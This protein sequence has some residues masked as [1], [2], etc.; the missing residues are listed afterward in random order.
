MLGGVAQTSN[1][2][3]NVSP[4]Q[5]RR[6]Q[7]VVA[8]VLTALAFFALRDVTRLREGLPWRN[9]DEFADFYCAGSALNQRASPYTYEPLRHCEHAVNQGESFRARLFRSNPAIAVPAPQPP[10]D[11]GP[12]AVLARL[13]AAQARTIDALAIVVAVTLCVVGLAAIGVPWDLAAAALLLSTG[14]VELN[15]AQVVPFALLALVLCGWCLARSR[16][17]QAGLT[18]ALTAIEPTLGLPVVLALLLFVP[19]ARLAALVTLL[20]LVLLSLALVGAPG[21]VQYVTAVLPA[22]AASEVHFPFQYSLTFALAFLGATDAVARVAGTLS[23]LLLLAIALRVAPRANVALGRREVLVYVPALCAI[24]AGPFLHQEELCFALPGLL[25]LAVSTQGRARTLAAIALCVL[26]VP[27][28]VVWGFK[29][30]FLASL[31][32]CAIILIRLKIGVRPTVAAIAAIAALI[33]LFELR[34]PRLP[35]PLATGHSYS[36]NE[37]VLREWR[38][39]TEQRSTRDP[40]WFAV[41]IPAWAALLTALSLAASLKPRPPGAS[42]ASPESSRGS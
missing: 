32:V 30:L 23:Y 1:Q 41:K 16:D 18:G 26:A 8:V 13:P 28:I 17:A 38:D 7:L 4:S 25:V 36:P 6:R 9:M 10:Y 3:G 39:Y 34:P 22:H 21:L 11:F 31:F 24:V 2:N 19:R 27:W 35:T 40:L 5:R 14:F 42:E 29:Q 12:F 15:T 20:G 37:I 33:Y